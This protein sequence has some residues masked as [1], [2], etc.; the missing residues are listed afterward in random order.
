M[1]ADYQCD[2]CDHRF[3]EFFTLATLTDIVRCPRCLHGATR[4]YYPPRT[5]RRRSEIEEI[6]AYRLRDGSIS[7]PPDPSL[8]NVDGGE[9]IPCRTLAEADRLARE[10]A[11]QQ[12]RRLS[13]DGEFRAR[14]D[15][16]LKSRHGTPVETLQYKLARTHNPLEKDLIREMIAD[17][18]DEQRKQETPVTA[19]A[20]FHWREYDR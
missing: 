2:S 20:Y 4:R 12:Q 18:N 10:V 17:L 13:D 15:D 1:M 7:I 11:E 3:E 14:M 8:G 19:E 16:A 9:R 5:R 6:V